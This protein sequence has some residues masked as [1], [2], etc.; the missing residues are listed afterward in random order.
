MRKKK[1][2]V[3]FLC[4]FFYPEYIS[5]ATL[6]YDTAIALSKAGYSVGA[7]C[8]YPKEYNLQEKVPLHENHENITI[9]RL[10]YVQVKRSNFLGRFVNYFSFTLAVLLRIGE[11]RKY[12]LVIV[13]SN[14][15]I[16]PLIAAMANMLFHTNIIFVCYDVYP[17][18]AIATKSIKEGSLVNKVMSLINRLVFKRATKIVALSNEMKTFLF[19]NRAISSD[20][21]IEVI[22]NWYEDYKERETE[23]S[24]KSEYFKSFKT[25]PNQLVISYFGNMGVC[26][27]LITIVDAIRYFKS[28]P[29]VRFLFAGHGSKMNE[30]KH[31]LAVEQIENTVVLDFLHGEDFQDSLK[32]SDCFLVSLAKG[33]TGLCVPSKTY[34]YMMAG[35]PILAIIGEDSDIARDLLDNDAGAV[36]EIGDDKKL[37]QEIEKLIADRK[38]CNA[39]GENC[40]SVYLQKYTLEHGNRRYIELI[41]GF[42]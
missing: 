24:I 30:L 15:P 12:K 3:L 42:L 36:I 34:S 8:G 38:L 13:Y 21:Q 20:K 19:K 11:L 14:P 17:E 27:D 18:I 26:Q 7:L 41:N 29:N 22:P 9:K 40:R 35:K 32:I 33:L 16:L 28:N 25:D 39:M 10:R 23:T 37:V 2:D 31:I 1:D 5:S 6:P 4:Q